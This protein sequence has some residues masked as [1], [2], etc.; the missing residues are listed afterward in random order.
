MNKNVILC[1]FFLLIGAQSMVFGQVKDI[2]IDLIQ[3]EDTTILFEGLDN[4][5]R[6]QASEEVTLQGQSK[7]IQFS[8]EGQNLFNINT[9]HISGIDSLKIFING[10]AV[11]TLYFK[12]KAVDCILLA[13]MSD[14]MFI[15]Q[16]TYDASLMKKMKRFTFKCN[17]LDR[18]VVGVTSFMF[19]IINIEK[20]VVYREIVSGEYLSQT[21]IDCLQGIKSG[22][23]IKL[24]SIRIIA[25]GWC[26]NTKEVD[27]DFYCN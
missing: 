1:L 18:A 17:T 11:K 12:S 27:L 23:V 20:E 26:L 25:P 8:E 5:I 19:L 10:L 4:I 6:I 7:M 2:L 21:A 15:K 3:Y 9:S 14:N 22:Y 24:Q 16:G 13:E